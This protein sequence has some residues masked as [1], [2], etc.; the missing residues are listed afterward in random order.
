MAPARNVRPLL[1]LLAYIALLAL[2]FANVEIQI[3]GDQGWAAGLPVTFR[4]EEHWLLD[5]F[6]GGRPMTG[7]HAWIFPFM[8]LAFHL[9]MAS[10]GQWTPRL[11]ARALGGLM[12]FWILEDLLWFLLNPAFGWAKLVPAHVWWHKHWLL[13]LPTDY[14]TFSV[15]GL[16]LIAWS[17]THR[18][19]ENPS[20]CRRRPRSPSPRT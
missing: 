7:Y 4:V 18:N 5:V 1:L 14:T 11:Q 20:C 12:V 3:E 17:Y 10:A 19:L 16:S 8:A 2:F 9:P 6:W 13:G 15:V